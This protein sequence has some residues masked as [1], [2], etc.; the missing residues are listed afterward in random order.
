[1]LLDAG[2]R[3][4]V[5]LQSLDLGSNSIREEGARMMSEA[6]LRHVVNLLLLNLGKN[7]NIGGSVARMLSEADLRHVVN[8][9]SLNLGY[10]YL[11]EERREDAVGG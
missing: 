4:V 6:G 10:N 2:L 11:G 8:P 3:H 5:D 1:M 7:N 9:Q